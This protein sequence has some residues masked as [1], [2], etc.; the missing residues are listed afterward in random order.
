[1]RRFGEYGFPES[2]AASFALLAY[3]SAWLKCHSPAAFTAAILNSQPMGFYAP[4]QLVRDACAHDIVVRPVDVNHSDWDCTLE[5]VGE[6][7]LPQPLPEAERGERLSVGAAECKCQAPHGALLS[8]SPSRFGERSGERPSEA[9]TISL[10]SSSPPRFGEGPGEGSSEAENLPSSSPLS[11]SGRGAGGEGFST[12]VLRLGFRLIRGMPEAQAQAI[13]SARGQEAFRSVRD[14]QRRARVSR[15]LL[16]RLTAADAFGS[17]GLTPRQALWQVL[18]LREV[19]SSL[20]AAL[21]EEPE[22][23][24]LPEMPLDEEM[25]ADYQS[26]GLSLK[27]HPMELVRQELDDLG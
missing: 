21:D 3:I 4:A 8:S 17:L 27:A 7:P 13:V 5:E 26:I 22:Q 9:E 24:P 19:D 20:F 18:A 14:V 12:Y 25:V 10:P 2:H 16:A 11:A 15:A 1:L 23:A 6:E